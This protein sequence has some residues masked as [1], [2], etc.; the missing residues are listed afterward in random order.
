MHIRWDKVRYIVDLPARWN[1]VSKLN[2]L[3]WNGYSEERE[4]ERERE[5]ES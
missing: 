4:R 5:R 3:S 2:I 1:R